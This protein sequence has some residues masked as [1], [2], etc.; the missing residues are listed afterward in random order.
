MET[1]SKMTHNLDNILLSGITIIRQ[2]PFTGLSSLLSSGFLNLQP[3]DSTALRIAV[4]TTV[5]W[6]ILSIVR[7]MVK[8]LSLL[9]EVYS[10]LS[11]VQCVVCMLPSTCKC[12]H[13]ME[14][15]VTGAF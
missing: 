4:A 15:R 1:L 3:S 7:Q 9:V 5:S 6:S 8:D 14:T 10:D 2:W 13:W 11:P 12:P